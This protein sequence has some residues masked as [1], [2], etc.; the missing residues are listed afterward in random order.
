MIQFIP[1]WFHRS[2]SL[3]D[4]FLVI[5]PHAVLV[6]RGIITP[7]AS[8][9]LWTTSVCM[10]VRNGI[11]YCCILFLPYIYI[12]GKFSLSGLESVYFRGTIFVVCPK[13]V[14]IVRSLLSR[15][16]WVNFSFFGA[17]RNESKP[18]ENLPLYGIRFYPC[19]N[20]VQLKCVCLVAT[21]T[22]V[23]L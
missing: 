11:N 4:S 18:N 3:D 8:W 19:T 23:S 9:G 17:L 7:E 20:I 15:F 6:N 16:S 1:S 5:R 14:I 10:C 21:V 2:C 13:H 22:V 12:S